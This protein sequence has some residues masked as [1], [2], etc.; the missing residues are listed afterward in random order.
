[1]SNS[2]LQK[3]NICQGINLLQQIPFETSLTRFFTLNLDIHFQKKKL[4][5]QIQQTANLKA[6]EGK[7]ELSENIY[8]IPTKWENVALGS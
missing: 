7:C 6:H 4:Q 8:S 2:I 1:M 3:I 5:K